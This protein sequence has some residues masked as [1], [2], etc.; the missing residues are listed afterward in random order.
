M[1]DYFGLIQDAFDLNMSVGVLR[2]SNRGFDIS[3]LI[4]ETAEEL[5]LHLKQRGD[6]L[7][8]RSYPLESHPH[9]SQS[10]NQQQF[11][12]SVHN[13]CSSPQLGI[14]SNFSINPR[15]KAR[16]LF[17]RSI[18]SNKGEQRTF[19]GK[20]AQS[21]DTMQTTLGGGGVIQQLII[22]LLQ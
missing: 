15:Q 5:R 9:Q 8:T 7:S 3:E 6:T 22:H 11:Q 19:D 1:I 4:L 14:S 16:D 20:S 2:N 18:S 13:T 12:P 10:I 21:G 17:L